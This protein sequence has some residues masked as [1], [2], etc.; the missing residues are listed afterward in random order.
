M[1]NDIVDKQDIVRIVNAFYKSVREDLVLKPF[2]KDVSNWESHLEN[3][4]SFWENV[5]FHTGTYA[6]N[7]MQKHFEVNSKYPLSVK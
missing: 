2:F 1:K 7:P 6:G 4:Y 5:L 3:M